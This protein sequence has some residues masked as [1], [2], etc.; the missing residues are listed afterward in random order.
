MAAATAEAVQAI[1]V[2]MIIEH[3]R[4]V[5][6]LMAARAA[7]RMIIQHYTQGRIDGVAWALDVLGFL[8]PAE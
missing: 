6:D 3:G 4:Q 5:A 7:N 8:G 2:A 1:R